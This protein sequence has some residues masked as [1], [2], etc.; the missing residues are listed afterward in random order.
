MKKLNGLL[1]TSCLVFSG[2]ANA[3]V[4]VEE[5]SKQTYELRDDDS[6]TSLFRSLLSQLSIVALPFVLYRAVY[7]DL[8]TVKEVY[9][10]TNKKK[11]GKYRLG[12]DT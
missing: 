10:D 6:R 3:Q 12:D 8:T 2:L 9:E 7:K 1:L 5:S 11:R 4:N